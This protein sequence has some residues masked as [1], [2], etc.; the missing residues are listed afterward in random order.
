MSH[1]ENSFIFDTENSHLVADDFVLCL[2]EGIRDKAS[3]LSHYAKAGH[4]PDY[5]GN[6]WDALNDCLRDLS[7]IKQKRIVVIHNDLPLSNNEKELS[8]YLEIL[9]DAVKLWKR[10]ER[11]ELLIVLPMKAEA[12]VARLLGKFGTSNV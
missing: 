1:S 11:H 6:N 2:P 4:F 12:I 8:T 3:L 9:A 10:H 5:F 7:W